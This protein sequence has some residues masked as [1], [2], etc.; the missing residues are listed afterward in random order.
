MN[1]RILLLLSQF[2][3]VGFLHA[4]EPVTIESL[5][6]GM[7]D[8]SER[9]R[10]PD[11]SFKLI[12]Y[13]SYNRASVSPDEYTGWFTNVDHSGKYLYD[14]DV[15]GDGTDE[16]V[17]LDHQSP[18]AIVRS[19]MPWR[20]QTRVGA[21]VIIRVYLDGSDTPAIEGDQFDLFDGTGMVPYPLAHPSLRSAVSFFPITYAQSCKITVSASPFFYIFTCREYPEDAEVESFT[22][23]DYEASASLISSV[24]SLLLDPASNLPVGTSSSQTTTIAAGAEATLTLPAGGRAVHEF[25]VEIASSLSEEV[26][27]SLIVKAEFDGLS[28]IWCPLSDFFG[29][30][31]GLH[32]YEGFYRSVQEDGTFTCRW[33]MPYQAEGSI[34]LENIS[35]EAVELTMS[36][37]T[38]TWIWDE[39]SM[40]FFSAWRAQ[41]PL[42]TNPRSDWNYVTLT[43]GRGVYVGDTL[44][45]WNPV[46]AWWGEGDHKIWV[47]GES[48]PSMFGTG[49]EDYYGYSW[50]GVSTDFYEHPF[51]AQVA[52]NVYDKLNRK[53][54]SERDTFGYSV[55]TRS[56]ALDGIAFNSS[57]QLDME[58]WHGTDCNM[59]YAV[60]SHWYAEPAV[61]S[62]RMPDS[63]SAV[64]IVWDETAVDPILDV[65]P[66]QLDFDYVTVGSSANLTLSVQNRGGDTLTGTASVSA[67]FVIVS[68]GSYSL[69]L[70]ESQDIV[71]SYSPTAVETDSGTLTL[72]G[73]DGAT[74]PVSGRGYV[75][76]V[77]AIAD[78][79][80]DYQS[81]TAEQ[82]TADFN[83]G[84]GLS[85]MYGEGRWN[86]FESD[87]TDADDYADGSILELLEFDS[88]VGNGG[89]SG[90]RDPE[91]SSFAPIV[92]GGKA[93]NDSITL[94]ANKLAVHPGSQ[95]DEASAVI[96][97]TAG[98]GETGELRIG[99]EVGRGA[100]SVS[101]GDGREF[102]IFKTDVAGTSSS[103]LLT[104][105]F[106]EVDTTPV[107]FS[108]ATTVAEGEHIDFVVNRVENYN[109]D[110]IHLAA[111]VYFDDS[112]AD[113]MSDDWESR[114]AGDLT[115]LTIDG[116]S[117]RDGSIDL[118][119]FKAGSDPLDATE[120]FEIFTISIIPLGPK[121]T[122]FTADEHSYTI[123]R[124]DSL[125]EDSWTP[126]ATS[127]TKGTWIDLSTEAQPD[128]RFYRVRIE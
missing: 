45:L 93:F 38:D 12:N 22:M 73:G 114:M 90:Y 91:D 127:L 39:R 60:A 49:T 97:W 71:V 64:R 102:Y 1:L 88:T 10:F 25:E 11:P 5:L 80:A 119:E 3:V 52:C 17:L 126:V 48:F 96:R 118:N 103:L 55:E 123:E 84:E 81:A 83:G 20:Y 23:S 109:A 86:Y 65:S 100:T 30:G 63:D 28:T 122:W 78:L 67:P 35:G 16:Y 56:R 105:I 94:E 34:S 117:D 9:A 29:T 101:G 15:N 70:E 108:I 95:A 32:P 76:A 116:D 110:E 18:G 124:K 51:H 14:E 43:G 27:R 113:G 4:V 36:A 19:W 128:A 31:V 7:V 21:S 24:G 50:G 120:R 89:N 98:A 77:V 99:G 54:T 104:E 41:Y 87:A 62:N 121:L 85:D 33:V 6:N 37:I 125:N 72:T 61:Q 59:D 13:S 111:T 8:R 40:Y 46:A 74:I 115:T 68:G 2:L 107:A 69:A 66:T 75:S 57:L 47:D 79:R 42:P 53:T 58:V 26:L 106:G 92:A 112:D 82:T 44:T